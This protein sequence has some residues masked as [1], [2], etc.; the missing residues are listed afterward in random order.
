MD[1][2]TNASVL[3]HPSRWLLCNRRQ[4]RRSAR[5]DGGANGRLPQ[6]PPSASLVVRSPRLSR[7]GGAI[8]AVRRRQE[9]LFGVHDAVGVEGTLNIS[10]Q[11][12]RATQF[13]ARS[14]SRFP[15]PMPCSPVDVP[16]IEMARRH[17]RVVETL[18]RVGLFGLGCVQ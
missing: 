15:I 6:A 3:A 5:D 9:D 11:I 17:Q 18:G 4:D 13:L 16:S 1:R 10:H 2:P 12:D 8:I 7:P 14:D